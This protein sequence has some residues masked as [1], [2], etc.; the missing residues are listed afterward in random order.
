MAV[1]GEAGSRLGTEPHVG[2]DPRTLG[3]IPGLKLFNV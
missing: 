3:G 1:K 2:L